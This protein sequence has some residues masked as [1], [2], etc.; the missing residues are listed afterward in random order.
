MTLRKKISYL[1]WKRVSSL[2]F[3]TV[4]LSGAYVYE[5]VQGI[6]INVTLQVFL[7]LFQVIFIF[8]IVKLSLQYSL[9]VLHKNL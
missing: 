2:F 9:F 5:E 8:F 7:I 4:L 1:D 3:T 6:N